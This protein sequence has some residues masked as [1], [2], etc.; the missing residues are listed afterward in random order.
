MNLIKY[1]PNR[2]LSLFNDSWDRFFDSFFEDFP[3]VTMKNP[4]VDVKEDEN[5]YLMEVE[6]PGLTDKD[7]EVKVEGNLLT[8]SSKKN[9][10]KEEKKNDYVLKERKSYSFSRSFVLPENVSAK[11]IAAEFKN[12]LLTLNVPKT[13]KAK[14]K[15]LEIK[16]K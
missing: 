2:M 6:L 9:E 15:L 11:E 16:V 13:E 8:L 7:I 3:V 12:G 10:E 4:A 1:R 5:G 14:P